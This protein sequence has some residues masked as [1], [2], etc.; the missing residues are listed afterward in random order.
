MRL[1][2]HARPLRPLRCAVT[3]PAD[4]LWT[5]ARRVDVHGAPAWLPAPERMFIH[6]AAHAA[7]HGCSRLVWLCDLSRFF[8]RYGAAMDW[9]LVLDLCQRWRLSASVRFAIQKCRERVGDICPEDFARALARHRISWRDRLVLRQT[10]HDG[11]RPLRHVLVNAITTPDFGY[12]AAYLF[13]CLRPSDAHL[14]A[15]Y[16]GR[17]AGWRI[18][19]YLLRGLRATARAAAG[20]VPRRMAT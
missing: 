13:A 7:Y 18:C 5:D 19:A 8:R 3:V 15:I 16:R 17:H 10:P 11:A 20:L 6:L 2:V 14:G 1:D 12:A 9:S 4:A